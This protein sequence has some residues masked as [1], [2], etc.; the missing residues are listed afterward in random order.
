MSAFSDYLEGKIIDWIKGT[1]MDTPPTSLWVQVFSDVPTDTGGTAIASLPRVQ[2]ASTVFD[3]GTG[4][5]VDG[6]YTSITNNAPI[7]I[8]ANASASATVLGFGVFTAETGGNLL[9]H[10]G[11]AS[12]TV[13]VG[14][15]LKFNAN[16]LTLKIY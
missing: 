1:Q 2:V 3:K 5:D 8:T 4:T 6:G 7:V 15:E 16:N 9:F 12:K 11:L 14:D 13:S 10:G